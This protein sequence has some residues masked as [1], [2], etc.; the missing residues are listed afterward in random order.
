[1]L[2]ILSTESI[3]PNVN[4]R[5]FQLEVSNEM[6]L[7]EAGKVEDGRMVIQFF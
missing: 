6:E 5:K 7:M 2:G 3:F 4:P 1:M